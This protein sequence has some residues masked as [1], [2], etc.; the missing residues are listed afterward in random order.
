[1]TLKYEDIIKRIKEA[2]ESLIKKN[3]EE[4]EIVYVS[5]KRYDPYNDDRRQVRYRS[6]SPD[7]SY[8]RSPR[9]YPSDSDIVYER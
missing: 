8:S 2:A 1:M 5:R 3:E 4:K 9:T 7:D 6:R